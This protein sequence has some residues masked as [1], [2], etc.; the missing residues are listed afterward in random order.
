[1]HTGTT[2]KVALTFSDGSS[3]PGFDMVFGA[4]G[5]RSAVASVL[6]PKSPVRAGYSG[7]RVAYGV[8]PVDKNWKFR[9]ISSRGRFNQWFG[10]GCYALAASYGGVSGIQHMLAVVYRDVNNEVV[11]AW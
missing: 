3:S 1:M 10:D 11:M 8:T 6:Y 7:L 2:G 5:V 9:D 4:D